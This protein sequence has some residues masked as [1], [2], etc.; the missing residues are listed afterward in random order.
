M[1]ETI[2]V[3]S[4]SISTSSEVKFPIDLWCERKITKTL[5]K[6]IKIY[7]EEKGLIQKWQDCI[8][9]MIYEFN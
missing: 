1:K 5:D 7:D 6:N 8:V 3:A 9:Q 4:L 2:E